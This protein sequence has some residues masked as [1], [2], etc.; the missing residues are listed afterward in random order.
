MAADGEG[1]MAGR[2]GICPLRFTR[3]FGLDPASFSKLSD[4]SRALEATTYGTA[5]AR[6]GGVRFLGVEF[7][8]EGSSG[9]RSRPNESDLQALVHTLSHARQQAAVVVVSVHFHETSSDTV[10]AEHVIDIAHRL[11]DA[12]ADAVIG[13][14]PH[15]L[16]GIEMYR[17]R[18]ILYSLGNVFFM[19]E[20]IA[21]LPRECLENEGLPTGASAVDYAKSERHKHFYQHPEFWESCIAV[22]TFDGSEPPVVE[23]HPIALGV[24]R[25]GVTRGVPFLAEREHGDDILRRLADLS[26]P[27]GTSLKVGVRS[28]RLV[29]T[30]RSSP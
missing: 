5:A 11:V 23:L 26:T 27:F 16:F 10:P 3:S 8:Q 19:L 21:M 14:G 12:G 30:L 1:P 25:V 20:S 4:V 9:L 2:P 24:D 13:H 17:R 29:G 28:G 6:P 18:P 15:Q 22:L 7:E